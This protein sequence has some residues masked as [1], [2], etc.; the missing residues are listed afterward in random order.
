M[1]GGGEGGGKR[2]WPEQY[3]DPGM[4]SIVDGRFLGCS[5]VWLPSK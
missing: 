1:V 5:H 2:K 4:V 3:V